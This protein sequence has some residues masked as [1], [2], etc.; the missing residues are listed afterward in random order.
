MTEKDMKNFKQNTN[1]ALSACYLSKPKHVQ[2]MY[3]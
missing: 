3:H 1:R 2:E